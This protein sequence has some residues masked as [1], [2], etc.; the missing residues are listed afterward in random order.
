MKFF[1]SSVGVTALCLVATACSSDPITVQP[2]KTEAYTREFLKEFGVPAANH[3]YAM[4]KHA[5][6]KVTVKETMPVMVTAEVDGTEY[7]F[8]DLTLTP[9]THALPVTIPRSVNQ[10]KVTTSRGTM[11]VGVDDTV[12]LADVRNEAME[13]AFYPQ[14]AYIDA[15]YEDLSSSYK[16]KWVETEDGMA[17]ILAFKP[18]ELLKPY[19][20]KNPKGQDNM[21]YWFQANRVTGLVDYNGVAFPLFRSE[22]IFANK[23]DKARSYYL[24]PV[25][26]RKNADGSK[27][28]ET[29]LYQVSNG[30]Q[31][32]HA[33][34]KL[35][36]GDIENN[37]PFPD[38]G[39]STTVSN[40]AD[41]SDPTSTLT[42]IVKNQTI[43]WYVNPYMP[44][45]HPNKAQWQFGPVE[46][47]E[48]ADIIDVHKIEGFTFD[49]GNFDE[50]F[51]LDEA[52]MVV[53]R[54]IKVT[55]PQQITE[56]NN[57][58]NVLFTPRFGMF[59]KAGEDNVSHSV[60]FFN[61]WEWGGKYFDE[62]LDNIY[63]ASSSAQSMVV[64]IAQQLKTE[65]MWVSD[66]TFTLEKRTWEGNFFTD[67]GAGGGLLLG[68][69]HAATKEADTTPRDFCDVIYMMVP[70]QETADYGGTWTEPVAFDWIVAAEDLGGS[71]DWDFNDVVF[72]FNDILASLNTVN[73]NAPVARA[74]GPGGG[75]SVR[76]I[77][78][79]PLAAGGT[80]PV[81]VTYTGR[82]MPAPVLP[83][84]GSTMYSVAEQQ[85]KD[86]I[87][88]NAA[89][90]EEGS[91]ILG[92]EVHKWLGGAGFSPVNVGESMGANTGKAISFVIPTE[93]SAD[94]FDEVDWSVNASGDNK[95][96]YGFAVLV[97]RENK[98]GID[99]RS[100][101]GYQ[102][103]PNLV[104]GQDTYLI[105][106]PDPDK[107]KVAPQLIL[108]HPDWQWP[109]ELTDI[110][111]AYPTFVDWISKPD[112]EEWHKNP[113]PEYVTK[114][115]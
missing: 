107:G 24:F 64:A 5:G 29:W 36:G 86:F 114:R 100:G 40:I 88:A 15:E 51:P 48:V 84:E 19:F 25:Y 82:V 2:D 102:Q 45:N 44:D 92:T 21:D 53:S 22:T 56:P 83:T 67:R 62:S 65:V 52:T 77:T 87:A 11:T 70:V 105:G 99:T 42:R 6:L 93:Y 90:E 106:A 35:G 60:P 37:K 41:I 38:L 30:N 26:W 89:K 73:K 66:H 32:P 94:N 43:I 104:L 17:P 49:D 61:R 31:T 10:L 4:A 91:F 108:M 101:T 54:G 34:L 75:E 1:H 16:M 103:V 14:S 3:N 71:Y 76:I 68:F 110:R 8:A 97:D 18:E 74:S 47:H 112:Y 50:A 78:V 46:D 28:Y 81:Y 20:D 109:Q 58:K 111:L 69:N 7:L 57:K 79:K 85:L 13:D 23:R 39:Y 113:V 59:I 63:F 9:G 96:L 33:Y 55:L 72:S 98:L 27:N 80:M 115:R 95:H 12:D